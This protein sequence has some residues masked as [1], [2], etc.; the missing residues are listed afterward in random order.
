MPSS[1]S[2]SAKGADRRA[3]I[4]DAAI[5]IIGSR[6]L[7]QLS[8]R[9]L[10]KEAAMPLGAIG[11]YFADKH[12]LVAEAFDWH[13]QRE[14]KRVTRTI[15]SIGGAGSVDDLARVLAG[16]VIDGLHPVGTELVAEYEFL[17]EATRR[18]ELARAST[19]W[20]QA[21]HDRLHETVRRFGSPAPATDT[22]I[23]LAAVA[24][25]EVDHLGQTGVA[26]GQADAITETFARLLDALSREWLRARPSS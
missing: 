1:P 19:A 4:L 13:A 9:A 10:A 25:L 16:F 22:R 23:L 20:L 5:T 3:R 21:L 24:G 14:L 18:P 8:M 17:L 6:G 15:A 7:A 2:M 11:Y 12:A 26:P